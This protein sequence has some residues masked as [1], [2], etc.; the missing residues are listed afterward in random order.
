MAGFVVNLAIA[1]IAGSLHLQADDLKP[2]SIHTKRALQFILGAPI[3][4]CVGLM[5]AVYFCYE[6]PRFYMRQD[7][8]NFN[9]QEALRI[10]VAIRP[11]KVCSDISVWRALTWLTAP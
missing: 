2:G 4:P 11:T 7:S 8:P 1:S 3:V 6:S 9:P 10:L 5:I